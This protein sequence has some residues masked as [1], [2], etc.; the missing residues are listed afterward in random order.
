ML[1][2]SGSSTRR[3]SWFKLLLD[4]FKD[5]EE[6]MNREAQVQFSVGTLYVAMELSASRW[7][8]AFG[9]ARG[10][11]PRV[12]TIVAGD[13]TALL[14]EISK[15]RE[16]FGLASS[17]VVVSCY[18]MGRDGYWPHR[19]LSELGITNLPIDA[20]STQVERRKRRAKT[21]RLD[22]E[23]LLSHLLRYGEGEKKVFRVVRV[24]S[25]EAE[26]ARHLHR[27]LEVLKRDRSRVSS[28]ILSL[29]ATQGVRLK[30]NA[31]MLTALSAV[32]LWDGSEL[33]AG[34]RR[35]LEAESQRWMGLS[36]EI[37]RLQAERRELMRKA[38]TPSAE[39]A[40][41]LELLCSVG[42]E[43]GWCFAHE[44]FG[45][46]QF[47]NGRQ[48]GAFVG[49]TGTPYDSGESRRDQGISK[50]GNVRMRWRAVELAWL[51]LRHQPA[52]K[53][54]L[55][56]R[57]RFGHGSPRQ[58]RI[59][60]VALARKLVIALWRYVEHGIMPEGALMKA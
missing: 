55:W 11:R 35:R 3:A 26:D 34:L 20:A 40:R 44:A 8:L 19:L 17:G 42:P 23:M 46:R 56:F 15:A 21:D 43:I 54:S 13:G 25:R 45:I 48:V 57:E 38:Q 16:R 4:G 50:A 12:K 29:L 49:L 24:L 6:A 30:V 47:D 36:D 39:K 52:S 51:W 28:R 2:R 10:H 31:Q 41:R 53:L 18:E 32:R 22:A 58:R 59:G 33:A 37:R 7:K 27:Q 14:A 9:V 1:C 60:I 5:K